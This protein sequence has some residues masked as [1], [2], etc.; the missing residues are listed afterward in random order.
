MGK[1]Q[2]IYNK[3]INFNK[4]NLSY[5]IDSS[6]HENL[7]SLASELFVLQ[8]RSF[9]HEKGFPRYKIFVSF[10]SMVKILFGETWSKAEST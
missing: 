7:N 9:L 5:K 10:L 6:I 8:Q 3:Y 4:M 1:S 2:Y